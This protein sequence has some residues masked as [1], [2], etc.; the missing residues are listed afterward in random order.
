MKAWQCIVC[1]FI[2]KNGTPPDKCPVCGVSGE[3]FVEIQ[4]P[5]AAEKKAPATPKETVIPET[6]AEPA[7]DAPVL[8]G[9]AMDKPETIFGMCQSFLVKH[10]AHPVLVH[11]PNGVLPASVVL[12]ILS[13]LFDAPLLATVGAVNLVF[14]L[15]ALPL[16][17]YTGLLEWEK[18][19]ARANTP[20]FRYKILAAAIT[21]AASLI[22]LI[23]YLLNP[24]VLAGS[25]AGVFLVLNLVMLAAAVVAGHIGGKLVFKD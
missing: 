8:P 18:K 15:L 14:V 17:I 7:I 4:L 16:V 9:P 3:K 19:Y 24:D 10:H 21:T 6:T 25:S 2:H 5:D 20:I 13:W 22:S 1:K 12:F 23:W 11:T